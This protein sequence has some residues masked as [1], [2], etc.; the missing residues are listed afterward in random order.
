MMDGTIS[1][2]QSHM[3]SVE[4]Q[5]SEAE[6]LIDEIVKELGN[7]KDSLNNYYLGLSVDIN[8][9]SIEKYVEHMEFLKLCCQSTREYVEYTKDA[10][11]AMDAYLK[12]EIASNIYITNPYDLPP[13]V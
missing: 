10:L 7:A 4:A 8:N 3:E 5:Y 9:E 11:L 6:S 13:V 2:N 12:N 1:L